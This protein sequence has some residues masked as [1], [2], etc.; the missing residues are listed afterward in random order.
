MDNKTIAKYF[1][2]TADLMELHGEILLKLKAM[3]MLVEVYEI[4]KAIC[5]KWIFIP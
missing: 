5:L 4:L 1:S 3:N 2:L